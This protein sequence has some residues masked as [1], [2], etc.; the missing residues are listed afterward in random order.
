MT[1]DRP[2]PRYRGTYKN[3]HPEVGY[4]IWI[5]TDWHHY[6]MDGDHDGHIYCPDPKILDTCITTEKIILDYEVTA[7]DVPILREGFNAGIQSFDDV[8]IESEDET[9]TP[10]LMMFQARFTFSEGDMH[11]KRWLR[12][13]YWKK[14]QLIMMAQGATPDEFEYWMPMFYNSLMTVEIAQ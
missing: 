9:I 6:E 5:P 13:V 4:S 14:G 7:E 1:E 3:E 8:E 11:R 12:V 2:G 10:T